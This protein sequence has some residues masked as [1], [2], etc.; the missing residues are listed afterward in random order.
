MDEKHNSDSASPSEPVISLIKRREIQASLAV[1]LIH[2]YASAIGRDRALEIA[3]SAVQS[4]AKAAGTKAAETCGGNTLHAFR[5][6]ICENWAKDDAIEIRDMEETDHQLSFRVARCRYAELYEEMGIRDLGF[7]LS[8]SRDASFAR[9]FNPRIEMTRTRT[10]MQGDSCCD[11][12]F[13]L[14]ER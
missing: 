11:F 8:C 3:T 4:D 2:G 6:Y 10:I 14:E 1:S 12:R 5:Q 9:G 7:C 13:I